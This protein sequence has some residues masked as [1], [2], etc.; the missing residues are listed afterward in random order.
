MSVYEELGP[1]V[2]HR[3]QFVF[4]GKRKNISKVNMPSIAYPSQ[5]IDIEI[6]NVSRDHVIVPDIVKTTFNLDT[7]STNKAR[8]VVNNVVRA[9]VKKRCSC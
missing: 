2:E 4:K 5:H 8:S 1:M 9:L 7:E 6:L 3:T